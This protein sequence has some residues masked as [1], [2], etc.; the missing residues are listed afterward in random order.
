[1]FNPFLI[2]P[3][4]VFYDSNQL[5]TQALFAIAK[6]LTLFVLFAREVIYVLKII[7]ISLIEKPKRVF[8][9]NLFLNDRL[10]SQTLCY[11]K[12]YTAR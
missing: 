4:L 8:L 11:A 2:S 10:F 5:M 6:L 9:V 3:N 1:M 7:K 12:L